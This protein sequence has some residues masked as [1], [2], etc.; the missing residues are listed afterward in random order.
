MVTPIP[1][2]FTIGA[3]A[4]RAGVSIDTLRYY[5]REGLLVAE[6]RSASGF[7]A[8]NSQSLER[9][10]FILRA[11]ELGFALQEIR[12]LLHASTDQDHGVERV[13]QRAQQ[14]LY[15]VNQQLAALTV[16]RD[17]LEKLVDACPG[18]GDPECCPIL[19][20]IKGNEEL[21][22]A[23]STQTP[24]ASTQAPAKLSKSGC[25]AA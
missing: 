24:A 14:R 5:E 13:K 6:R 3:L 23:T 19:A 25:C 8:Y 10:Q 4:E 18:C 1:H 22:P 20:A 11:K 12:E 15:S 7:R 17:R 16:V 21:P 9:L 2:S